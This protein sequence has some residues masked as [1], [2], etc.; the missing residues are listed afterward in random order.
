MLAR[1]GIDHVA[2]HHQRLG[3]VK[4]I[5]HGG[6]RVGN[7]QHV[8]FVDGGP[9]ADAGP[10]EAETFF[11]GALLQLG[12]R[13]G[14]MLLHAGQVGEAQIE[15]LHVVFLRVFKDFFRCQCLV[16]PVRLMKCKLELEASG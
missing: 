4:R 13:I 16:P 3:F 9:S 1:D 6:G 11:E 12:D 2:Q 15:L 10:V 8:A 14:N 5:D 7:Q